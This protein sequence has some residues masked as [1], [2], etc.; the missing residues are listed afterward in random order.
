[1][2]PAINPVS[3]KTKAEG[4]RKGFP[5]KFGGGRRYERATKNEGNAV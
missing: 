2:Y 3:P 5:G 1:M 4:P